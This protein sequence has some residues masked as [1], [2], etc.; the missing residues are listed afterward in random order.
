MIDFYFIRHAESEKNLNRRQIGGRSLYTPLTKTGIIQSWQL[1]KRFNEDNIVFDEI[2][3]ST[4]MRTSETAKIVA[5]DIYFPLEK[6]IYSDDILELDQGEWEGR[7]KSEI[8]TT[9]RVT[10]INKDNWNYKAP[11]GE[12]QRETE[13]R[14][15]KWVD[16][17][18]LHRYQ[19]NIRVA[20]FDHGLGIKCM[21]RGIMKFDPGM[22]YKIVLD[23]TS[24]TQ[25][26][27]NDKGWHLLSVNDVEH[28]SGMKRVKDS[29]NLEN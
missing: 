10:E 23:N 17:T 3:A 26:Q 15:L 14:K 21:L 28:L 1:A 6:I 7:L 19:E 2:Y 8:Y 13:E 16:E 22:T 27:Y 24:I 9:E 4:A 12:S 18:F 29:N 25:L 11:G 20:V 5:G